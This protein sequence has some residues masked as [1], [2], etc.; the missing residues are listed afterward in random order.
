MIMKQCLRT[1]TP[2]STFVTRIQWSD[3]YH[4]EQTAYI[5]F[6]PK[7]YSLLH[8]DGEFGRQ[9]VVR[10]V[11]WQIQPIEAIQNDQSRYEGET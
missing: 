2:A 9:S 3:K 1:P 7:P 6:L 4:P 11:V 10:F 5:S 8:R